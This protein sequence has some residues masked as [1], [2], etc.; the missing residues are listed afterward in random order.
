[1]DVDGWKEKSLMHDG[2]L[3]KSAKLGDNWSSWKVVDTK[4]LVFVVVFLTFG[5]FCLFSSEVCLMFTIQWS[6]FVKLVSMMERKPHYC[7]SWMRW[8]G[9][10]EFGNSWFWRFGGVGKWWQF[11]L[12]GLCSCGIEYF[13]GQTQNY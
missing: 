9:I 8:M 4:S 2:W 6:H 7:C 5:C 3:T 11:M 10:I 12:Q 13:S 1:M